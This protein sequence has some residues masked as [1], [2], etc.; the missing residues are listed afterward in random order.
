MASNAN[1][2]FTKI[3]NG[4][5]FNVSIYR[6]GL[7][8]R[9]TG[10]SGEVQFN[11]NGAFKS[12]P[13]LV[14]DNSTQT[15]EVD[16]I[17]TNAISVPLSGISMT[18]GSDGQVL[19][20]DGSGNI[21][22][23]D[24]SPNAVGNTGEIQF[25]VNGSLSS[26][27]A[28]HYNT[29]AN[30]LDIAANIIPQISNVYDLG[31]SNNQWRD[32]YLS[33]NTIYLGESTIKSQTDSGFNGIQIDS[34]NIISNAHGDH[35]FF[36]QM[37]VSNTIRAYSFNVDNSI[38]IGQTLITSN[39][40]A[41]QDALQV[42][43]MQIGNL[44]EAETFV[45]NTIILNNAEYGIANIKI[46]DGEAGQ[47]LISMGSSGEVKWDYPDKIQSVSAN[48][49]INNNPI[50]SYVK[51]LPDIGP[52]GESVVHVVTDGVVVGNI[53]S[54][55]T[56]F[57]NLVSGT[58]T[59]GNVIIVNEL[60]VNGN[61]ILANSNIS[62]AIVSN[63]DVVNANI[64]LANIETLVSNSATVD[65]I[66]ANNG[67]ITN[68]IS[69]SADLTSANIESE[70]VIDSNI[71]T[72]FANLA[73]IPTLISNSTTA[74]TLTANTGTIETLSAVNANIT[75]ANIE[76]LVSNVANFDSLTANNGNIT[77]LISVFANLTSA[78]IGTEI[79]TDSNIET[80]FANI[81][82]IPTLISNS[83]AANI[84]TANTGT[85]ANLIS[86]NAL[87]T[88]SN[89]TDGTSWANANISGFNLR[90]DVNGN[91]ENY[92]YYFGSNG[93]FNVAVLDSI[94][95]NTEALHVGTL[96]TFSNLANIAI[97]GGNLN[98]T[99]ITD[100][101]SNLSWGYIDRI[102]NGTSS[103]SIPQESGNIEI[104]SNNN[105]IA[106]ITNNSVEINGYITANSAQFWDSV[107]TPVIQNGSTQIEIASDSNIKLISNNVI[108]AVIS[109]T[110]FTTTNLLVQG[111]A[112]VN[113]DLQVKGNVTYIETS[114]LD[115][116]DINITLAKNATNE[117]Q[118]NGGGITIAG[119]DVIFDYSSVSNTMR[120][121]HSLEV[122]SLLCFNFMAENGD[123]N[124]NFTIGNNLSILGEANTY[125]LYVDSTS[126]LNGNVTIGG[127]IVD[128]EYISA[129][130]NVSANNF[131]ALSSVSGDLGEFNTL[132]VAG[133][134][135]GDIIQANTFIGDMVLNAHLVQVFN[136]AGTSLVRG[137]VV[138]ISGAQG[139]RVKIS[140]ANNSSEISS[141]ET[142]G[143]VADS[144]I[145]AGSTGNI[146]L[147][148][149][150]RMLDTSAY[151]EGATIYLSDVA[152]QFTTTKPQAPNHLVVIGWVER[153]HAT[154]GSIFVKVDNGWEIDE[155]HNVKI[156]SI[157]A[158]QL[159]G[160]DAAN[161]VWVNTDL[162]FGTY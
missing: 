66:I 131:I 64:T 108:T 57:A 128:V 116:N 129:N 136:G 21:S 68:L 119:A 72:L 96:A 121:T 82:N 25:N 122:P 148:G 124:N 140:L 141:S 32:L 28:I 8:Q 107:T 152:G 63:L 97:P 48:L 113:G 157:S 134:T 137:Q 41:G 76:T 7:P 43:N 13:G 15:L 70:T 22:W 10:N 91:N 104:R 89:I 33:G 35:A 85:I 62:N 118:A 11:S 155:L 98:Q 71:E 26:D 125:S 73:N 2:I 130:A 45:A 31:S 4:K 29:T 49:D 5:N 161:S 9:A 51:V 87:L 146:I 101:N 59:A 74:N 56:S 6:S 102:A 3:E 127:S 150:L 61:A 30:S 143:V 60:T 144:I 103:V 110:E 19:T 105:L 88:H 80:L 75:V 38:V 149:T 34:L 90:I 100:G 40:G 151:T 18:G 133:I 78:N 37:S 92:N 44:L 77:N 36:N 95:A 24:I 112:I 99:I 12:S 53:N 55:E 84:L 106:N 50:L 162:D 65:S 117:V 159:L 132:N 69:L 47:S 46:F 54:L 139:N 153:T 160:W 114:T 115:I 138:K 142:V 109:N 158:G 58:V 42:R 20:T 16:N 135:T 86:S 156:T 111:S 147:T 81:A 79:V 123:I 23:A 94:T 93:T 145:S 120:L 1:V 39:G 14:F 154:A 67:N 126:N 52:N 83:T 27:P 17:S